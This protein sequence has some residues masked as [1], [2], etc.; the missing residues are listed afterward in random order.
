MMVVSV[1]LMS[2][3]IIAG[4]VIG[5]NAVAGITLVTPIY[6]L[7]AFV[8]TVFSLGI[9]IIYSREMGEFNKKEADK[10]FGFGLVMCITGG[11]W[12]RYRALGNTMNVNVMAWVGERIDA[13]DKENFDGRQQTCG[14]GGEDARAAEGGRG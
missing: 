9:P 8:A 14:T 7:S 12:S 6:S 10:A 2:D 11:R 5:S 3:S 13:V 1:L 4:A